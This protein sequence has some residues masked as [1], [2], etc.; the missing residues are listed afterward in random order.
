MFTENTAAFFADFGQNATVG[1]VVVSAIFDK[2]YTLGSVGPVGMASSQPMLTL[3]TAN[4]PAN[5]VG[6][7][8]VVGNNDAYVE[9]DYVQPGYS[10]G[11]AYYYLVGA[12]E[13]DGT[14]M[15]QLMLEAV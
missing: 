2:G 10:P 8:V 15:S 11:T 13:P 14:G 1:G 4:V 5:P 9:T 3:A 12:H 6:T 7:S